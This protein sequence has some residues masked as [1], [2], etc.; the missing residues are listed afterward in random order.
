VRFVVEE[1]TA[2]I[3]H[4]RETFGPPAGPHP[5][6]ALLHLRQSRERAE[7]RLGARLHRIWQWP[8]RQP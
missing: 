3:R 8:A 7:Q 4:L 2:G 1:V 5:A 6:R